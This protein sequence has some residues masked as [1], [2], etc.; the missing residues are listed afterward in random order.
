MPL[1]RKRRRDQ[2]DEPGASVMGGVD[3]DTDTHDAAALDGRQRLLGTLP[4]MPRQ[5][6]AVQPREKPLALSERHGRK[7]ARVGHPAWSR[8]LPPAQSP[9]PATPRGGPP[10]AAPYA[11]HGTA[12]AVTDARTAARYDPSS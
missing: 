5:D 6:D 3:A 12:R 11:C 9:R 2:H 4:T 8:R 10:A 1:A 7:P